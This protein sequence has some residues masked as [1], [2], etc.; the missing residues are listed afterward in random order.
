MLELR[1]FLTRQLLCSASRATHSSEPPDA[2]DGAD[3]AAA[4]SHVRWDKA[5]EDVGQFR[6]IGITKVT[7]EEGDYVE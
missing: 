4:A 5:S 1:T 3:V 2:D 6:L 7:L